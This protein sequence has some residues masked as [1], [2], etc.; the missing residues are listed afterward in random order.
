MIFNYL[1]ISFV[2]ENVSHSLH[3]WEISDKKEGHPKLEEIAEH[4]NKSEV[5]TMK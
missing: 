1:F 4:G 3:K 2:L 5:R